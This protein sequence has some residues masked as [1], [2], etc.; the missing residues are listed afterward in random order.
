MRQRSKELI[1]PTIGIREIGGDET[2]LF[3]QSFLVRN[4]SS[5]GGKAR[6]AAYA[7]IQHDQA[8]I[9]PMQIMID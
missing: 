9:Y 3:L 7:I 4:F 6:D 8:T 1:H 5:D 2:E